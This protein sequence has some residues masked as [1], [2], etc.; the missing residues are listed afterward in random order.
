[1]PDRPSRVR[2]W[3]RRL[4]ALAALAAAGIAIW[5]VVGGDTDAVPGLD[6]RHGAKIEDLTVHSSAV[7]AAEPVKVVI[8]D[9][10]IEHPPLLVFLHGRGEDESSEL[11]QP[12]FDA[13]EESGERAPIIAFPDGGDS[14]YWHDRATGDW[15]AYVTDEVIPQVVEKFDADPDRVAI[16]GISMGGYG[17]YELAVQNPGEF[18]AVG[19]H[20]PALWQSAGET[21]AGA[22]DDEAD[23]EA[24]DVIGQAASDPSPFLS[25]P[26]WLDAGDEDPF[27]A[28][29][30]AFVAELEAAGADIEVEH[31][32]GGH[33]SAYWQG[34]W[35]DY[36]R[37][38]SKALADCEA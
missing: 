14:S 35:D 10:G 20:S 21:A 13:L 34:H 5:I 9:S 27:L 33:E 29:D 15:G 1:V 19:G 3:A 37:F 30:D 22:F 26:V 24:H 17:A 4:I 18:C 8:P 6:D 7:D 23:F 2:V 32:P 11:Y 28:G 36:M 25:Q 12:M 38:Y 16:G 31:P